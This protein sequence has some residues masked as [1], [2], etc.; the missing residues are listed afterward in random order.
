MNRD[1]RV[2][3]LCVGVLAVSTAVPASANLIVNGDFEN[4]LNSWSVVQRAQIET[5]QRYRDLAGATGDTGTGKFMSFGSA[6]DPA[7]GSVSQTIATV[8]GESYALTFSYGVFSVGRRA[9]S[10]RVTIGATVFDITPDDSL[11]TAN[12]SALLQPYAFQFAASDQST[13]ITFS[14]RSAV[15]IAVD[16][17]LDDVRVVAAQ[18]PTPGSIALVF[19]GLL[20]CFGFA[21]GRG[22]RG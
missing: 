2:L 19:A 9:Q 11:T 1:V 5:S 12:L 18:V 20:A 14:D 4:D 13:T 17:L 10:L 7:L 6:N 22:A 3:A 15:T 8:P 16:G 21:G